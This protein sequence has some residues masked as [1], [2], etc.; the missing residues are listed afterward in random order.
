MRLATLTTLYGFAFATAAHA[1]IDQSGF[2][3]RC[4]IYSAC[5]ADGYCVPVSL[6]EAMITI[7]EVEDRAYEVGSADGRNR[8]KLGYFRTVEDA[9][10]NFE[11]GIRGE[12]GKFIIPNFEIADGVGFDVY[13]TSSIDRGFTLEKTKIA[14]SRMRSTDEGID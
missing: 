9:H 14:C 4:S 11:N 2:P 1:A 10:H 6:G 3:A 13:G 12:F 7:F 5:N 8:R